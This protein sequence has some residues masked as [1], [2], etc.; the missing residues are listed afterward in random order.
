[1]DIVDARMLYVFDVYMFLMIMM[2]T[3]IPARLNFF[4]F[5]ILV[6]EH[7]EV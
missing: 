1:M 4:G 3:L 7:G 2:D 6:F 5:L